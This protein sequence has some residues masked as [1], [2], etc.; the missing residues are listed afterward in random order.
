V[1]PRTPVIPVVFAL[2]LWAGGLAASSRSLETPPAAGEQVAPA[3]AQ[4][5]AAAPRPERRSLPSADL[6]QHDLA[7]G[8]PVASAETR[9]VTEEV[10][11]EGPPRATRE[12]L[13]PEA[14]RRTSLSFS[15]GPVAEPLYVHQRSL[16]C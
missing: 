9:R 1:S 11:G 8:E 15:L 14:G 5:A 4:P 3:A 12:S 7:R 13:L 6:A 2:A 10:R 16:R